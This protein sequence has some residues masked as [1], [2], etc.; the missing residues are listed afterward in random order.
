M[1]AV[2]AQIFY[3]RPAILFFKDPQDVIQHDQV[4]VS[5]VPGRDRQNILLQK[6]C[7]G[8]KFLGILVQPLDDPV[9]IISAIDHDL[10]FFT[11]CTKER[12]SAPD[13]FIP[14]GNDLRID[15]KTIDLQVPII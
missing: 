8:L 9:G 12:L 11:A 10:F 1:G 5:Q 6:P 2:Q 4:R 7:A 3:K 15:L 14:L 13:P